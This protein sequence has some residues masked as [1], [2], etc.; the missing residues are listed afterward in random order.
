MTLLTART[1][2]FEGL[3]SMLDAIGVVLVAWLLY[4]ALFGSGYSFQTPALA[5]GSIGVAA[6]ILSPRPRVRI[7]IALM[8]FVATATLSAFVHQWP[9]FTNW[10]DWPLLFAP[11]SHLLVMVI[12]VPGVAHLLREPRRLAIF[13]S[14]LAA[15]ALVLSTQAMFD[16]AVNGFAFQPQ[17]QVLVPSVAQWGGIHDLALACAVAVPI[18]LAPGMITRKWYVIVAGLLVAS[19][20][21]LAALALGARSAVVAVMPVVLSMLAIMAVGP[22]LLHT[23]RWTVAGVAAGAVAL[24]LA[25]MVW[26][27]TLTMDLVRNMSGRTDIW[28]ATFRLIRE[29]PWLGVGP[30]AYAGALRV[31]GLGEHIIGPGSAHNLF[32]HIAAEIGLIGA[33]LWIG[34]LFALMRRCWNVMI[35][36]ATRVLAASLFFVLAVMVVQWTVESFIEGSFFVE[37]HRVLAWLVFAAAVAIERAGRARSLEDAA[38][39]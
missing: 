19:L 35:H 31:R 28:Q 15:A 24:S 4:V 20:P 5:I 37:R 9:R 26:N 12:F 33:A 23:Y 22:T 32:L 27:G 14:A 3:S 29:E 11:V 1:V 16:Q 30:G 25:V 7:P 2:V 18:V 6:S 34:T 39:V 21:I 8:M 17:L 38:V 13:V 10:S 36:G